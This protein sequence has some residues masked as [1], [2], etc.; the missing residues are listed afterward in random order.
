MNI[1]AS[2][3]SL[4]PALFALF[5]FPATASGQNART[6]VFRLI[7]FEHRNEI[8]SARIDKGPEPGKF[9]EIILLTGNFTDDYQSA[10]ADN[11]VRFFVAD[12]SVPEGRRIVAEGP[13]AQGDRQLFLLLPETKGTRPYRVYAMNDD[14]TSFPMGAVRVLNMC[15]TKVRFNLAGADM[16]PIDPGK[17]VIYP[18][19]MRFDEWNMYQVRIDL[20]NSDGNWVPVSSPSWKATKLKRDLVITMMDPVAQYPRIA[21]YKDIPPWRKPKPETPTP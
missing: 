15:P 1:R 11:T 2:C 5:L 12:P 21:Y 6:V 18:P 8:T 13:L 19:V 9:H 7:C 3:L 4:I 10:F 17:V 16:P 20:A 14:E